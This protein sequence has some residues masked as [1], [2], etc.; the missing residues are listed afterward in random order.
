MKSFGCKMDPF[1]CL[2]LMGVLVRAMIGS[3]LMR[4]LRFAFGMR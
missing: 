2:R 3:V 4:F 1:V